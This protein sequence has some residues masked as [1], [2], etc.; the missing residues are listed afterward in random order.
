MLEYEFEIN[1]IVKDKYLPEDWQN[2]QILATFDNNSV[3][4]NMT[5]S[6]IKFVQDGAKDV[7]AY[8]DNGILGGTG[9]YEGIPFAIRLKNSELYEAFK[10]YLDCRDGMKREIDNVTLKVKSNEGLNSLQ[11][12]SSAITYGYLE[13]ISELK[14]SDYIGVPYVIN[15]IPDAVQLIMLSISVYLM[16]KEITESIKRIA[17]DIAQVIA[18]GT[19]G[20]TGPISAAVLTAAKVLISVAY[21]AAMVYYVI[22]LITQIFDEILSDVRYHKATKIKRL[23][24]VGA[25]HVGLTFKSSIF[26]NDLPNLAF[27]PFKNE[28]GNRKDGMSQQSGAPNAQGIGYTFREML[29]LNLRIFRAKL[30]IIDNVLY[31]ESEDNKEFWSRNSPYQLPNIEILENGYNADELNSNYLLRFD[32][33]INDQNTIDSFTGTNYLRLTNYNVVND[34]KNVLH[35]GLDENIFNVC[36]GTR[37]NELTDVESALKALAKVADEL[38]GLFGKGTSFSSRV[39]GRIGSL[40]LS[41]DFINTPKILLLDSSNKL[42]ANNRTLFSAKFLYEN[43]HKSS[44]FVNNN[45]ENQY[46]IYKD[47]QIPFG[48]NDFLKITNSSL[49]TTE[50]GRE[51]KF[52]KIAWTFSEDFATVDYRIREPY[53][54]NLKET[55]IEG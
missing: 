16:V 54:T 9:I 50:D 2:L 31:M 32:T 48:F 18:I 5:L 36:L 4:P 41:N 22:D 47:I 40:N 1:G 10:G 23:L 45:F 28:K 6:D 21:T 33:D 52:D 20:V 12:R 25:E 46:K 42:V 34:K 3:Q 51:G 17:D 15:Y 19:S 49:F 13:N 27:L 35:K 24:E 55:F 8:I 11:N 30:A 38:T 37:K 29:E 53:T 43:Y 26:D 14:Q 39:E 7:N 44:S